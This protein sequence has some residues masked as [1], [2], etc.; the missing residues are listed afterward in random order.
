VSEAK[1]HESEIKDPVG[2]W[3]SEREAVGRQKEPL[4]NNV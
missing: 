4:L 3:R 1:F 2:L